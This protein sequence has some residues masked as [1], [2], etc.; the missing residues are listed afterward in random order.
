MTPLLFFACVL[1]A[2][3]LIVSALDIARLIEDIRL[4][5]QTRRIFDQFERDQHE[6]T[7]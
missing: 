7:D 1:F 6:P 4:T 2:I 3:V 5:R